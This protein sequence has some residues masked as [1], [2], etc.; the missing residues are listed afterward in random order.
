M[1]QDPHTAATR[2]KDTSLHLPAAFFLTD[3]IK[4]PDPVA[5]VQSLPPGTGVIY[6]H[7]DHPERALLG[8]AIANVCRRRGLLLL[9]AE[10]I[11]LALALRADGIHLPE[12][13]LRLG[14][15]PTK[16][17][18]MII[19]AATHSLSAVRRAHAVGV[20]ALL[21]SPVFPTTSHP[22]GQTL[23]PHR[24]ARIANA[25]RLPVYALGGIDQTSRRRLPR[26]IAGTAAI[27]MH[28]KMVA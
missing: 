2:R 12:W 26:N 13:A 6:R 9:I 11:E 14:R 10:D 17:P 22:G 7:Y 21:V 3:E 8:E 1:V 19:T 18:G 20:D 27:G 24:L 4:T 5:V 28:T 23:G 15:Q 16:R 25:T